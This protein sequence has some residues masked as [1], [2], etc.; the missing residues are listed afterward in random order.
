[1]PAPT[2]GASSCF[3]SRSRLPGILTA[4][5]VTT[6]PEGGQPP[7]APA[8]SLRG[9]GRTRDAARGE[10]QVRRVHLHAQE[11]AP[12][13]GRGDAGGARSREGVEDQ[14]AGGRGGGH[15]AVEERQ[16]LLG[17]V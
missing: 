8:E 12:R 15:H 4:H 10:R 13:P 5:T 14:V 17:G 9:G 1:M 2:T 11:A 6:R 7:V 3:S 16:R